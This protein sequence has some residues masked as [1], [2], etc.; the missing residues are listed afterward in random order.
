[1][2][3]GC[4]LFS[5]CLCFFCESAL[6]DEFKGTVTNVDMTED[7][8]TVFTKEIPPSPVTFYVDEETSFEIKGDDYLASPT[9]EASFNELN[10]GDY[11]TVI[12][13]ETEGEALYASEI[14]IYQ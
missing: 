14:Y 3:K 2:H 12:A 1:M 13:N 6:A 11:V 7:T 5:L 4:I 10:T 9:F 8:F